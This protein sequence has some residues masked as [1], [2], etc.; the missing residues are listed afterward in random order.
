MLLPGLLTHNGF[1]NRPE[2]WFNTPQTQCVRIERTRAI[3][4]Q[5]FSKPPMPPG[6][7]TAIG[8]EGQIRT[9][10]GLR[11]R[12]LSKELPDHS[13]LQHLAFLALYALL[14]LMSIP[15]LVILTVEHSRRCRIRTCVVSVCPLLRRVGSAA[16]HNLPCLL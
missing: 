16:S 1:R 10:N 5:W 2:H 6:N 13:V 12:L 11:P 7:Y 3:N 4:P 14:L 15:G 9:D 8:A